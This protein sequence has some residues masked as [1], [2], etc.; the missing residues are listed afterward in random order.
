M[1]EMV[2]VGGL[3]STT[4]RLG[5]ALQTCCKHGPWGLL[6]TR[7]WAELGKLKAVTKALWS[8]IRP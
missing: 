2:E 1:E 4:R 5:V 6:C 3:A 7:L 8:K